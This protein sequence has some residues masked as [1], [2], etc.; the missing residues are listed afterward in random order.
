LQQPQAALHADPMKVADDINARGFADF[1][2]VSLAGANDQMALS[3]VMRW[4]IRSIVAAGTSQGLNGKARVDANAFSAAYSHHPGRYFGTRVWVDDI[5][6]TYDSASAASLQSA[7][8]TTTVYLHWAIGNDMSAPVDDLMKQ[9]I[10]RSLAI[11]DSPGLS[12]GKFV[13]GLNGA[14]FTDDKSN[15]P[16]NALAAFSQL[17]RFRQP[18][19]TSRTSIDI[20]T[21]SFDKIQG[22][23][24][25]DVHSSISLYLFFGSS[26]AIRDLQSRLDLRLWK[27]IKGQF[28]RMPS[29][30]PSYPEQ[31]S[32]GFRFDPDSES[33]F[34]T[35]INGPLIRSAAE[36][37]QVTI[38]RNGFKLDSVAGI[39]G[40]SGNPRFPIIEVTRVFSTKV[41]PQVPL[42]FLAV[43]TATGAI[44]LIG[45]SIAPAN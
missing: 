44:V 29:R 23:R 26:S 39:E 9:W 37:T 41:R 6:T 10:S 14:S 24:L 2:E 33:T 8:C 20:P 3:P 7:T 45:G 35:W 38:D 16:F 27:E 42:I 21:Y 1:R 12:I 30:L 32:T 43:D 34:G 19:P 22:F 25:D 4:Y 31:I 40:V 28:R 11:G 18:I 36:S 15:H 17:I 13:V 5:G